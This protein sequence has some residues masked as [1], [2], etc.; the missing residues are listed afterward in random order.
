M[1]R[2]IYL[3][4]KQNAWLFDWNQTKQ[5]SKFL[6]LPFFLRVLN[7]TWASTSD[8]V[9]KKTNH[10]QYRKVHIYISMRHTNFQRISEPPCFYLK[11]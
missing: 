1:E 11:Q 2:N 10:L 7:V 5:I 9:S 3:V 4:I 6:K 8:L